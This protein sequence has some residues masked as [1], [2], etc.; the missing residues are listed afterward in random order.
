MKA[1]VKK[2]F[3]DIKESIESIDSYLGEN[4]DYKIYLQD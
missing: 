3:L 4:K 1:E 2:L